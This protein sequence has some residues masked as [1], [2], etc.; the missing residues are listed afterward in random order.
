[1]MILIGIHEINKLCFDIMLDLLFYT[2]LKLDGPSQ[3]D[4]FD[5]LDYLIPWISWMTFRD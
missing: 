4:I 5:E 3:M 1:M 2:F